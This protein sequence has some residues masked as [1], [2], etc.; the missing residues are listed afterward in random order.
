QKGLATCYA[1]VD[2][3]GSLG[4]D[5]AC[6]GVANPDK[7]VYE[8]EGYRL[9]TRTEAEFATRA[10]TVSTF[11]SGD[12][13]PYPDDTECEHDPAL[14]LIAWYCHNSGLRPHRGGEL[15]PNGFGLYDMLGNLLEWN[16]DEISYSSSPGGRDPHGKVG[17]GRDRSVYRGQYDNVSWTAR[18]AGR[19]TA[20][21]DSRGIRTGFRLVR[22]L[23]PNPEQE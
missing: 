8:C 3:T 7:S 2:C 23:D 12:I 20:P 1:P 13:T 15:L 10:G 21:W 14:D 16:S 18:T 4:K 5:L 9:M 19:G 11:Y 6:A 22:T 17:T